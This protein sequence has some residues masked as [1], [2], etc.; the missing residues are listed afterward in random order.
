MCLA[1]CINLPV[2]LYISATEVFTPRN[3]VH[4]TQNAAYSAVFNKCMSHSFWNSSC[5]NRYTC[6]SKA[7]KHDLFM[8]CAYDKLLLVFIFRSW[9]Q[10]ISNCG[11]Q[12]VYLLGATFQTTLFPSKP[13]LDSLGLPC[14]KL[15]SH[16]LFHYHFC[17]GMLDC[18]LNYF[19]SETSFL[20]S[21]VTWPHNPASHSEWHSVIVYWW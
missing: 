2:C 7:K 10:F 1:C 4:S 17:L 3:V 14:H 21:V 20:E 5:G 6:K 18:I 15:H 8:K 16:G 9:H 11:D 19:W 13:Q 12:I